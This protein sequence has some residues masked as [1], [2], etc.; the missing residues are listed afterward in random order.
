MPLPARSLR[1][2]ILAPARTASVA[3]ICKDLTAAFNSSGP[4][5]M[6][7]SVD[8]S[9]VLNSEFLI[10]WSS[11]SVNTGDS[12]FNRRA[13][14][15]LGSNKLPRSP[16]STFNDITNFSRNGS[17]AGFVTWAKRCLK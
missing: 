13:Y 15:G 2:K 3:L 9:A 4:L 17:I 16:S 5:A 10:A 6:V 7:N 14:S 12:S 1:T 8:N 11:A